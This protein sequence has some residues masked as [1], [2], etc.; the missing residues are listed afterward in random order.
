[1]LS[2]FAPLTLRSA[3]NPDHPDPNFVA[4]TKPKY[5]SYSFSIRS[6]LLLM[7]VVGIGL[8]WKMNRV[9]KLRVA[10]AEVEQLG[11][12]ISYV[13]ELSSTTSEP[14]GPKWFRSVLGEDFFAEVNQINLRSERTDDE[15]CA[16]IA[17]LPRID[18]LII[19]SDRVTDRGL[20]DIAAA[21]SLVALEIRSANVTA[22][23][24]ASLQRLQNLGS[25]VLSRNN[26]DTDAWL[27]A[28]RS[29]NQVRNL[30][31]DDTDTTDAGLLKLESCVWLE[32]VDLT[33]AEVTKQGV[34]RL[35]KSLPD[36]KVS[37]R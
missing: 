27:S 18:S 19:K 21:N 16:M 11:G 9:R 31:L 20:A 29:L 23:G 1:M 37:F 13:H 5:R 36:C 25:L 26:S 14:P 2:L 33:G 35:R 7:T 4:S 12:D 28:L 32:F 24:L 17:Q 34:Q 3:L 15:T 8:A 22:S 6:L 10:V 30:Y